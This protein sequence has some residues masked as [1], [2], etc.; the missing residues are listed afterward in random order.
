MKLSSEPSKIAV[1]P[2][3]GSELARWIKTS[4]GTNQYLEVGLISAITR[5][6]HEGS[7]RNCP[8]EVA[9]CF[10]DIVPVPSVD[11]GG[12]KPLVGPSTTR[13]PKLL[14]S[15]SSPNSISKTVFLYLS[16]NFSMVER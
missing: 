8:E 13:L 6:V 9:D 1:A 15:F 7:R 12:E 10:K 2:R 5:L 16:V 4:P 3:Y 14:N 11:A